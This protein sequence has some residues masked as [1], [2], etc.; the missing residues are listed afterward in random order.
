MLLYEVVVCFWDGCFDGILL[1]VLDELI[2]LVVCECVDV[3]VIDLCLCCV[4]LLDLCVVLSWDS[5][6]SDMDL[7][8]IDLNGE[9]V[10]YGNWLI[11]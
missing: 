10:Y 6:N 9:C 3:F 8:V 2:W 11:Y 5:D 1:I 4:M 7:W